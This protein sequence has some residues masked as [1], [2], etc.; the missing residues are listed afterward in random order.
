MNIRELEQ[1]SPRWMYDVR[2]QLKRHVYNRS[3]RAFA[4]G[5][6]AR[7]SI[8][9]HEALQARQRELRQ[10]LIEQRRRQPEQFGHRLSHPHRHY[11]SVPSRL[12]RELVEARIT[13][14]TVEIFHRGTRV[15]RPRLNSGLRNG[16]FK[17]SS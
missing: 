1:S 7:D 14:T 3:E 2:D 15:R 6:A 11:Y 12:I 5:D 13:S 10:Y 16:F 9:T 4:A 17:I 8:V